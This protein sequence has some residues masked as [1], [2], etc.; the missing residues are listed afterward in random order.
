MKRTSCLIAVIGIL[1]AFGLMGGSI[2]IVDSAEASSYGHKSP[3]SLAGRSFQI[4]GTYVSWDDS[5]GFGP[6]PP[7]FENCYS[8]EEDGTWIDPLFPA[9]GT[10]IQHTGGYL[11]RYTAFANALDLLGPGVDLGL[12]QNGVVKRSGHRGKLKLNA[13]STVVIGG[14]TVLG[15]VLSKGRAVHSCD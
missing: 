13:Y 9:L 3:M 6:K 15:V 11:T 1:L 12:I 5:L 10:W 8:F 7:D 4:H 2:G 14:G